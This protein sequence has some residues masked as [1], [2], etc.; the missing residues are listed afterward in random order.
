VCPGREL[1]ATI[2]APHLKAERI[3]LTFRDG[4][5]PGARLL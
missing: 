1:Q 2:S 3:E 4:H 5:K